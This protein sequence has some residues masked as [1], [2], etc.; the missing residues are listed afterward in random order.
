MNE[1]PKT[2]TAILRITRNINMGKIIFLILFC[3]F[4]VFKSKSQSEENIEP[5]FKYTP[6]GY[7][8]YE[9]YIDTYESRMTRN[10]EMYFYPLKPNFDSISGIDL[11][12]NLQLN[13]LSLQSRAGIRITGPDYFNAKSSA[14]IEAD[15]FGTAEDTK[16]LLR[17]RHACFSLK[18]EQL[19]LLMGQ[20]W[21]AL[22]TPECF[23][24][25]IGF[26]AAP[27]YNPLNRSPQIRVDYKINNLIN[28]AGIAAVHGYHKSVGPEKSQSNS[29]VPDIQLQSHFFFDKILLGIGGGYFQ[30][31]PRTGENIKQIE[32]RIHAFDAIFFGVANYEKFS[33]R[34][35]SVVGQ[36]L[37][38]C[39]LTGGFGQTYESQMNNNDF[40]YTSL[41]NNTNWF[42]CD[43]SITKYFSLGLF[44]GISFNL[45]ATDKITKDN[46]FY[47]RDS[48]IAYI[49]RIAPRIV[50]TNNKLVFALEY[51]HDKAAYAE[52]FDEYYR[53]KT[54]NLKE[55][56]NHRIL[57]SAKYHFAN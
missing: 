32:S 31:Q 53:P 25:T 55:G 16:Y 28:F 27:G 20:Y 48:N 44:S 19:S 1:I 7:V 14:L 56:V 29:G 39:L 5:K 15:F 18:W 42:D 21:H 34:I 45:G 38:Y 12:E 54:N 23:P 3:S 9:T 40:K 52:E 49:I 4:F 36:N 11:N 10:G 6:Y 30:L 13:M 47:D 51:S 22:H 26:G 37:S 2:T 46:N 8:C 35:K 17:I 24:K 57:F 50:Y 33:V 43:Y 41:I